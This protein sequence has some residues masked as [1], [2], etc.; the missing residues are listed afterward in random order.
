MRFLALSVVL[1][2]SSIQIAH[3]KTVV[4]V[5][6]GLLWGRKCYYSD[7][8]IKNTTK[9]SDCTEDPFPYG[10]EPETTP[11]KAPSSFK[12]SRPMGKRFMCF[13]EDGSYVI[14]DVAEAC[15]SVY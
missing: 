6:D 15:P 5:N 2:V 3:A 9:F 14:R 11:Y 7:G 8:T 10:F 4:G 1:L 13:Y 12:N